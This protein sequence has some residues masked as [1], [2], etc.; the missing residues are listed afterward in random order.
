MFRH[1]FFIFFDEIFPAPSRKCPW[2]SRFWKARSS[3]SPCVYVLSVLQPVFRGIQPF[4]RDS[5]SPRMAVLLDSHRVTINHSIV[6][7][8]SDVSFVTLE[9]IDRVP[10][11]RAFFSGTG[12]AA[13]SQM[14][15]GRRSAPALFC[16][17]ARAGRPTVC[18]LIGRKKGPASALRCS[19]EPFFVGTLFYFGSC[20]E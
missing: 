20:T 8:S 9:T 12:G 2:F 5:L 16:P 19:S 15:S 10:S 18:S 1:C 13:A 6:C 7:L 14:L 4:S 3:H 11:P 17:S